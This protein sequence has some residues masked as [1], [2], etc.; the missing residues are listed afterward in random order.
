MH[1]VV[2]WHDTVGSD[3][4][5]RRL[6]TRPC[7]TLSHKAHVACIVQCGPPCG[8][9]AAKLDIRNPAG[10][11]RRGSKF[12]CSSHWCNYSVFECAEDVQSLT[13]SPG[14]AWD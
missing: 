13:L 4:P 11:D 5:Q 12:E 2:E 3:K 7:S 6:V 14:G 10:R 8:I 1:K 9:L